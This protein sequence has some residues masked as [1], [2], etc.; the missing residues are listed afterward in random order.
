MKINDVAEKFKTVYCVGFRSDS[1]GGFDW[2]PT[3]ELADEDYI[4]AVDYFAPLHE[5]GDDSHDLVR[6][7]VEVPDTLSNEEITDYIDTDLDFY[8]DT[9]L[10]A[11]FDRKMNRQHQS[12]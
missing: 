12:N 3:V 9:A 7:D 8:M 11:Q 5:N 10:A 2:L 1:S 6:F 4:N